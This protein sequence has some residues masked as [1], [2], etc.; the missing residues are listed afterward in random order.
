VEGKGTYIVSDSRNGAAGDGGTAGGDGQRRRQVPVAEAAGCAV[1]EGGAQRQRRGG[2]AAAARPTAA[3]HVSDG[4]RG[5]Q[6]T[7]GSAAAESNW[8]L[9]QRETGEVAKE[10]AKQVTATGDGGAERRRAT[11]SDGKRLH[12]GG[13]QLATVPAGNGSRPT[14]ATSRRRRHD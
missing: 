8:G 14:A 9:R 1:T 10:A 11:A 13:R 5:R 6:G 7:A 2:T 4:R 12:H 3:A